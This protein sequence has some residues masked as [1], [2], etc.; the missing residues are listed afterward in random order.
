MLGDSWISFW[1][2]IQAAFNTQENIKS[3]AKQA[4]FS[5]IMVYIHFS[6]AENITTELISYITWLVCIWYF[7]LLGDFQPRLLS[8]DSCQDYSKKGTF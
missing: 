1:S 8:Y 6:W 4:K 3:F 2:P 7:L 5:K